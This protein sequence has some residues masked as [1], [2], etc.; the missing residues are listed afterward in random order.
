MAVHLIRH[1]H[2]SSPRGPR[3]VLCHQQFNTAQRSL[4]PTP[5]NPSRSST[6]PISLIDPAKPALCTR[7]R[8]APECAN[9]HAGAPWI[10]FCGGQR[11]IAESRLKVA[12]NEKSSL[13]A[14]EA[15]VAQQAA[16]AATAAEQL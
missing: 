12:I 8:S 9:V 14:R 11:R 2:L 7:R 5:F 3:L 13:S 15:V 6:H 4:A 1:R 10:L 16:E